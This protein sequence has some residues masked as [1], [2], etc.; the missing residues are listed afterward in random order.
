[1]RSRIN[2]SCFNF[3]FFLNFIFLLH[4]V[5]FFVSFERKILLAKRDFSAFLKITIDKNIKNQIVQSIDSKVLKEKPNAYLSD[6]IRTFERQTKAKV[7]STIFKVKKFQ[8]ETT[9]FKRSISF[10]DLAGELK[11]DPFSK[12]PRLKKIKSISKKRMGTSDYLPQLLPSDLSQLNTKEFKFYGFFFR[13]KQKLEQFWGKSLEEKAKEMASKGRKMKFSDEIITALQ[14][15]IN[16]F[17]E[18]VQI[19]LKKSSGIKLL[20]D[21]A[22]ESFN[23]AGPFLNPPKELVKRGFATFEWGFIVSDR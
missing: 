1:M 13:I 21:A 14:I 5:L 2:K 23:A 20:D 22:I 12:R 11:I 3:F 16:K 4:V 15:T 6:K 8:H 19:R 7:I 17:G 18:I 10:S 9:R